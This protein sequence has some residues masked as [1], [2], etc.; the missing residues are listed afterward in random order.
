[1]RRVLL[2]SLIAVPALLATEALAQ[3]QGVALRARLSGF[4]EVLNP[5]GQGALSTSASGE[6]RGR[7]GPG[8]SQIEYTL[9][10]D[11]PD[12]TAPTGT[13]FV[14]QAHFHLGQRG[15]TGGIMVFLCDSADNPS[16]ASDPPTCPSPGGEVSGV[17]T[18]ADLIPIP[19]QFFEPTSQATLMEQ[20]IAAL[21]NGAV[22][23]NVHTD[24]SPGGEIRGQVRSASRRP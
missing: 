5:A 7:I 8:G 23:V 11:F 14:N 15:T 24:R 3:G 4:Q 16:A 6:F 13:Q 12:A 18:D 17:L 9:R 19:G 22:Y 2:A 1:M 21:R 20:L 10:Y